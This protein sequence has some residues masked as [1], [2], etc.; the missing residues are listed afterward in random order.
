MACME[1]STERRKW[2]RLPLGV[3]MF[4]RPASND[5]NASPRFA[6]TVNISAGGI[7]LASRDNFHGVEKLSLE[8][9]SAPLLE[10]AGWR[11]VRKIQGQIV[12]TEP[13]EHGFLYALRFAEPLL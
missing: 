6:T 8:I 12:R 1:S 2:E 10:S 3:P 11:A 9:P 7:L 13:W 5:P 4:V